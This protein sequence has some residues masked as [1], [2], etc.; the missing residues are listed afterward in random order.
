[1]VDQDEPQRCDGTGVV[2]LPLQL[3]ELAPDRVD[4]FPGAGL[5]S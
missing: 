2:T 1:M 3:D 5:V 4:Q